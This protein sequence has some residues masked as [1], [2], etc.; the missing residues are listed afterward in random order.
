[1]RPV[2]SSRKIGGLQ[3]ENA[4]VVRHSSS[5]VKNG[6]KMTKPILILT[7]LFFSCAGTSTRTPHADPLDYSPEYFAR[8]KAHF[9]KN[10]IKMSDENIQEFRSTVFIATIPPVCDIYDDSLYIGKSNIEKLYFKP[11]KRNIKL[12]KGDQKDIEV[13]ELFE[14]DNSSY[15][16]KLK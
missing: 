7:L 10:G 12:V 5:T 4:A 8:A 11:G 13:I 9:E 14:G 1:L 16:F 15:F 6:E 3:R 2:G